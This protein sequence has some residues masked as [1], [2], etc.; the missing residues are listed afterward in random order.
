MPRRPLCGGGRIPLLYREAPV[1]AIWEGSGNVMCL[2]VLRAVE[3]EPQ[4]LERVLASIKP[5]SGEQRLKS[6][7]EGVRIMFA[8]AVQDQTRAR[9]VVE[10]LALTAAGALLQA[11]APPAVSDAFLATRL[12]GAFRP[13]RCWPWRRRHRRHRR[14]RS[15]DHGLSAFASGTFPQQAEAAFP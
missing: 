14:A 2:D 1:N 10:L 4:T 7:V 3:Q 15:A 9:S 11:Y 13:L 6:A 5:L 8:E 12:Y